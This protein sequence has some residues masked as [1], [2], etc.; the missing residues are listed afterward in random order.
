MKQLEEKFELTVGWKLKRFWGFNIAVHG[1][2]ISINQ[3]GNVE[4]MSQAF[5]MNESTPRMLPVM[6]NLDGSDT[7]RPVLESISEFAEEM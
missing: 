1:D 7:Q 4:T 6:A 3:M 5:S 2:G